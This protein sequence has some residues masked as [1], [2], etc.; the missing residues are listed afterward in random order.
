MRKNEK[1][2]LGQFSFRARGVSI[3][4]PRKRNTLRAGK[5]RSHIGNEWNLQLC[6]LLG[7]LLYFGSYSR[8]TV[9]PSVSSKDYK[10]Y[11]E[12]L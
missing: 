4:H 12:R 9:P 3:C 7:S 10:F 2:M 6:P 8:G 1:P 11:C 5:F